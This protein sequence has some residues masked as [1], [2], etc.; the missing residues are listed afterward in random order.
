M[1]F[2][3]SLPPMR[4]GLPDDRPLRRLERRLL[5][6]SGLKDLILLYPVYALLFAE[7]GL[8][9]AEISSLFAL[10]S[11]TGL[12]VEVP[13]GAWADLVSRRL[14]IV[15]GPLLK[16]VGCALWVL[17]PSYG[18]FALGFVLWGTGSALRSGAM[19]ALVYEELERLGA[20]SRYT[21]LIGR[22]AAVSA[23][24]TAAA[25]AAAAPVFAAG[26]FTALG[27]ASVVA[28]LLAAAVAALLPE[29]RDVR[30]PEHPGTHT[31]A[32]AHTGAGSAYL[33]TLKE[34]LREVRTGASVRHALMTTVLLS[35]VWEA[36]DEYVPLL[37]AEAG[38]ETRDVPFLVLAV[39]V[40]VTL[41]SLLAARAEHL[42]ARAAGVALAGAALA[43]VVGT[44]SGTPA[45]FL[46]LA[47]A[48]LVFQ[49][50]E[51]VAEAR[52]QAAITGPSRATVTS[53]VGLGTGGS[54]L[55]VYVV[56][57]AVSGYTGHGP[58]FA[59]SAVPY[60]LAAV[61]TFRGRAGAGKVSG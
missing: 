38:A 47:L 26:G 3:A 61:V 25:T 17:T 7:H 18:T 37:A 15:V 9:T 11:V 21:R 41:G 31:G 22:S 40:G 14:L 16:A 48:F 53:L 51:V 60:L 55:M 39:W 42:G 45:G 27:V 32:G 44:L 30:R 33:A 23:I 50:A 49:A 57:G 8:T 52:L 28:C 10:W 19:E 13:S 43:T 34:G 12:V 4:S 5:A 46:P 6:Y 59:L 20:A 24:A 35:T 36:L 58:L 29:H 56:Y 2:S 1:Q 54:T